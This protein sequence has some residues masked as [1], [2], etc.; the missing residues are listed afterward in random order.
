M[1]VYNTLG[2][3][4]EEFTPLK[5]GEV[6]MY[7]CGPTV[8][9]LSHLG[10]ARTYIAFDMIVRYLRVR[11]YKVCYVVNIT[12]ID[13]KIIA[14]AR[15][16]G[17]A[18]QALAKRFEAEFFADMDTLGM[19]RADHYPKVSGHMPEIIKI[20]ERLLEKGCAYRAGGDVYFSVDLAVGYGRLSGQSAEE[21]L[22]GAR[23]EVNPLKRNQLDFALW[24]GAK[25]GEPSWES[26]WGP[27]RPGW[28]VECSAMGVKYLGEQFDIHGGAL[29][30]IFPHHENEIQQSEGATGKGP[31]VRYWLHTG[32]LLVKGE[33]MSKSLGNFITIKDVLKGHDPEA[34]RLFFLSVHYRSP[35]G[36]EYQNLQ[37]AEKN[38]ER[39]YNALNFV[40]RIEKSTDEIKG[41]KDI[42]ESH[43][44]KFYSAMDDDFNTSK[45]LSHVY[46]LTGEIFK[47]G[48]KAKADDLLS[49]R[50]FLGE[51]GYIFGILQREPQIK[52]LEEALRALAISLGIE[53]AA[54]TDYRGAIEAVIAA[55][56]TLRRGKEYAA[57]D[58]I[59]Q[60]LMG[61]GVIL[62]DSKDG[63]VWRLKRAPRGASS[64]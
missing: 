15:E 64:S 43:K 14:R 10:H 47:I 34:L 18:P 51:V 33:K 58:R 13:D 29:D 44:N 48:P 9:D 27:G 53:L 21:M 50:D 32:F 46:E 45:A 52:G 56:E 61:M 37:S 2:K 42:L 5:E 36:F 19:L 63:P 8:Y 41:I 3:K 30:L 20:I 60:E 7:V 38:L 28:H 54:A 23:V 55:R 62:E 40:D 12:D 26:P 35:I 16:L 49:L 59:R 11:G 17:E 25:G 6:G 57:A 24:K 4:K 1:Q 31:F 39:L 22:A